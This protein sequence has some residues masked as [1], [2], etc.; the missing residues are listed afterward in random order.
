LQGISYAGYQVVQPLF[1]ASN[2]EQ[3]DPVIAG[4]FDEAHA[5]EAA[6]RLA[7]AEALYTRILSIEPDNTQALNSIGFIARLQDDEVMAGDMYHRVLTIDFSN[8]VAHQNLGVIARERGDADIAL[9][10]FEQ[11]LAV[12]ESNTTVMYFTAHILFE[13]RKDLDRV[14]M[15]LKNI[16]SQLPTHKEA[17]LLLIDLYRLQG[18]TKRAAALAA[19]KVQ[20]PQDAKI[21]SLAK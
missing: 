1:L 8:A 13:K 6:Q 9:T 18:S 3:M 19:A 10:H 4:L 17:H 15:I 16:I 12:D 5:A 11:V 21:Q 2:I 7:D 20:F 14:E